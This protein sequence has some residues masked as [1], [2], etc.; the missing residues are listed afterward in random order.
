MQKR[1]AD[2][3]NATT[4]VTHDESKLD[5]DTVLMLE[6]R[7]RRRVQ[8]GDN[9]VDNEHMNRKKSKSTFFFS[10]PSYVERSFSHAIFLTQ[11]NAEFFIKKRNLV[12]LHQK[13][14]V[15]VQVN[16]LIVMTMMIIVGVIVMIMTIITTV[17][18]IPIIT[19]VVTIPII[20]NTTREIKNHLYISGL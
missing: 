2:P 12:S 16:R 7:P 15:L 1:R 19:I 20:I 10:L 9:V 13:V 18:T 14:I 3:R 6:L 5:D 17:V 8:W 11:Q 4:T